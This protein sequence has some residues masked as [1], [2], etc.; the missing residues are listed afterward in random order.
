MKFGGLLEDTPHSCGP[1]IEVFGWLYR[2][3]IDALGDLEDWT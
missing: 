3:I 2:E 1:K